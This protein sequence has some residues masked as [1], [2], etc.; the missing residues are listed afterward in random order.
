MKSTWSLLNVMLREVD[1]GFQKE[2]K[3]R[4][5]GLHGQRNPRIDYPMYKLL[6][7]NLMQTLP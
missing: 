1:E 2:V 7:L 4:P 3:N 5:G 6:A